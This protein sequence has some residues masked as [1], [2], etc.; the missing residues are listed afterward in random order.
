M[1]EGPDDGNNDTN[2]TAEKKTRISFIKAKTKFSLS[3][4]YIGNKSY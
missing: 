3:L 4:H 1:E 2:G